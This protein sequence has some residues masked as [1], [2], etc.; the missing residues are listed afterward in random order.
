VTRHFALLVNPAAAGGRA[1]EVLPV[2]RAELDRLDAHYRVIETR[3][4]EHAREEAGAAANHGETVATLGGDGLV[5]PIA[6]VMQG[7]E[8]AMALL[9]GGRGNDFAR[10]LG[11]PP[12]PAAAARVAV[13]GRERLVDMAEVDGSPYVGIASFGFDSDANQI[14]NDA[15]LVRG[16][17]V[18]LYAALRTLARWKAAD[19]TVTVDGE[20]HELTG[21]SV[22]VGNS[23]YFGG[24]MMMLPD[25]EVDDGRLDVVTVSKHPRWRYLKGLTQVF[26]GEHLDPRWTNVFS[27]Q[28]VKVG[29]DRPFVIYADGDPIGATPATMRVHPRSLRV[30]VPA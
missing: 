4:L 22:A 13:Q 19:F 6:G 23:K 18:Y 10:M 28:V 17:L 26:K 1:R 7:R 27:G 15:K 11:I 2:V 20:R 16:N 5:G 24:G 12:D 29:S 30:V 8:A 21:Y 9:P 14:A 3:S 25:A